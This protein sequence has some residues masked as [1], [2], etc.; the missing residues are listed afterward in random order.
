MSLAHAA[1]L[2]T[3][4]GCTRLVLRPPV[5]GDIADLVAHADNPRLAAVLARL[6]SPYTRADAIGFVEIVARDPREQVY[7]LA[8]RLDDRLIGVASLSFSAE[9]PP[10]LGYWLG[11]TFWRQGYM[12]EALRA[13]LGAAESVSIARIAARV[14]A[15]NEASLRLLEGLGFVVISRAVGSCGPHKDRMI[16]RLERERH[17]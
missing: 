7:A 3:T 10:E 6:P 15:E 11:E 9:G 12:S 2:P 4:I 13:V 8:R 1:A 5:R 16:V 17:P 14:L